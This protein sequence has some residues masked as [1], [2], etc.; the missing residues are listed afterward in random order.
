M[1]GRR[2]QESVTGLRVLDALNGF[3]AEKAENGRQDAENLAFGY[4]DA[5]GGH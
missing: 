5:Q 4:M 3:T 2:R 1:T